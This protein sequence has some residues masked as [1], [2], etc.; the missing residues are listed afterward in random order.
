MTNPKRTLMTMAV[1]VAAGLALSGCTS[2]S[3]APAVDNTLDTITAGTLRVGVTADSKPYAYTENGQIKGFDVDLA[4]EVAKRLDL[5]SE[6]VA[7]EFS[8]LIPA[9]ANG[10]FDMAAAS[11]SDTEERRKTVDFSDHYFIG[12]ITVLAAKS[13]G[14]TD[15]VKTL[16]GKRLGIIQGTLQDSYAQDHFTGAEL[17]RFPDNNSAIAALKAGTIDAHFLDYPVAQDYAAADP[18]KSL[19]I[20]I[21]IEVPEYPVGFPIKKGNDVLRKAINGAL[22]DIIAD[23]TWLKIETSYFP[24]QP[25]SDQFKPVK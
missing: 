22:K 6:F 25:V 12:Y 1:I 8:A 21:N 14:I 23:G 10:Q 3:S 7:Q 5:K 19:E 2:A 18:N 20:A 17:V 16:A 13:A 24:D 9:V 15:D 4:T 11:T